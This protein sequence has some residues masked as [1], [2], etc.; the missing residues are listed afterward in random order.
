[1]ST[2]YAGRG[3]FYLRWSEFLEKAQTNRYTRRKA[4]RFG[5]DLNAAPQYRQQATVD[6]QQALKLAQK[7]DDFEMIEDLNEAIACMAKGRACYVTIH[8]RTRDEIPKDS[9]ERYSVKENVSLH[10]IFEVL[11]F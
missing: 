4:Q 9:I 10:K 5:F 7:Q 2:A 1:M 3:N 6:Y 8:Y 11:K